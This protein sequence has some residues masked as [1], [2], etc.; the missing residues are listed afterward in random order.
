MTGATLIDAEPLI[1]VDK[2][3]L[4]NFTGPTRI[5]TKLDMDE[6]L[7]FLRMESLLNRYF[8]FH[9]IDLN[10]KHRAVLASKQEKRQYGLALMSMG[11]DTATFG[12]NN[13]IE[14]TAGNG[15]F[16]FN[17]ALREDHCFYPDI[18]TRVSY[19]EIN[20]YYFTRL[21]FDND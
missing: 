12:N 11:R 18:P 14:A 6:K 19:F 9:Q 1:V 15:I 3:C 17:P 4:A 21:L 8:N 13:K 2:P 7:G 5:T 10:F 16:T 20:A